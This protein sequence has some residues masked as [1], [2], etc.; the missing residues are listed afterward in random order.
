MRTRTPAE[1]V[2]H[3]AI[4]A[5]IKLPGLSGFITNGK[6]QARIEELAAEGLASA[7]V[8]GQTPGRASVKGAVAGDL[9]AGPVGAL[10][11][12]GRKKGTSQVI[13][14]DGHG[15]LRLTEVKDAELAWRFAE[16]FNVLMTA[17]PDTVPAD[18]LDAETVTTDRATF[19]EVL[20]GLPAGADPDD[21]FDA[22]ARAA[23]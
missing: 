6:I 9:I 4:R 18:E 3:L 20:R 1:T 15:G 11:G 12:A 17:A 14:R 23:A 10:V 2:R 21:V 13:V 5:G 7:Q 22:L 8:A 16:A 19:R